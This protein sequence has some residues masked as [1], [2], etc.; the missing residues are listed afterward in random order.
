M[1]EQAVPLISVVVPAYNE[2]TNLPELYLRLVEVFENI[3]A[4]IEL[5]VVDD[6]SIDGTL[7]WLRQTARHD[8]RIRYLSFSRNFGHQA[9]VTA[10]L[11]HATGDAVVVMDADLQDP[12]QLIPQMLQRWREG[13]HVIIGQR[14]QRNADPLL[15]RVFAWTY[16]RVLTQISETTIPLDA[17]D[18]CLLDRTVVDTLNS[19]PE[20][21]RYVRGLRAWVG[22]RHTEIPFDRQQR[23]SGEPKYNFLK[24]L[25]LAIDGLV[26]FSRSPLRIATY[27]GLMTGS[28][29]LV[30][31]VFFIYWKF[32]TP[33]PAPYYIMFISIC[34]FISSIQLLTFGIMGEYIGRIYDEV[35]GRPHYVVKEST[36]DK[37]HDHEQED[38]TDQQWFRLSA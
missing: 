28:F 7:D 9:G 5:L 33:T 36:P 34:L 3:D 20:R 38:K 21:N 37:I 17:G 32:S 4:H 27:L 24:S 2:M 15:K 35:R 12:P 16:Y 31:A 23:F 11:Q 10:G 8:P 14:L 25:S 29:A 22:F 6:A 19:L 13:Y 1:T 30:M 18:F 26:S